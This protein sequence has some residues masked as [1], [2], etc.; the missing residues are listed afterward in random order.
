[1]KT[2]LKMMPARLR[3]LGDLLRIS[4]PTGDAIRCKDLRWHLVQE[5]MD[6]VS[7]TD[8]RTTKEVPSAMV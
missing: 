4:E 5:A 7:F 8:L 2:R 6:G 1:M 3:M